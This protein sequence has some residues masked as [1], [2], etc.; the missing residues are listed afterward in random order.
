MADGVDIAADLVH[1]RVN[2]EAGVVG[3]T[4]LGKGKP[5]SHTKLRISCKREMVLSYHVTADNLAS[6]DVEAKRITGV[7]EGKVLADG[8]HQDQVVVLSV[9]DA[10]VTG[11]ALG[12]AHPRPVA[13]D[14]S[15]VQRNVSAVLIVVVKGR[16][17]FP[18]SFNS[19]LLVT[20]DETHPSKG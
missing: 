18:V 20:A 8:V 7:E 9:L 13:E 4:G 17:A 11:Y 19:S 5:M 2:V 15:H 16:N 10:D 12:E 1:L 14:G 6:V 3:R